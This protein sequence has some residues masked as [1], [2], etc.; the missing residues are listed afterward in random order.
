MQKSRLATPNCVDLGTKVMPRTVKAGR[1]LGEVGFFYTTGKRFETTSDYFRLDLLIHTLINTFP[2]ALMAP[3]PDRPEDSSAEESY[4]VGDKVYYLKAGKSASRLNPHTAEN[5][6]PIEIWRV[7]EV[8]N[9]DSESSTNPVY[10]V[11]I[12]RKPSPKAPLKSQVRSR[13]K[14]TT[15]LIRGHRIGWRKERHRDLAASLWPASLRLLDRTMVY[16]VVH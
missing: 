5:P 16:A 3:I 2:V 13:T 12:G 14:A 7:G 1:S 11:S 15:Q 10:H 9:L 4:K 8:K 6:G